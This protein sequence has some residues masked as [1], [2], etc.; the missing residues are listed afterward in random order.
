MFSL[1]LNYFSDVRRRLPIIPSVN[2][3]SGGRG[4]GEIADRFHFL[5]SRPP[6]RFNLNEQDFVG[7]DRHQVEG[8]QTRR[9]PGA[10]VARGLEELD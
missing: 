4:R 2:K 7:A 9:R 10:F 6:I 8:P 5:R 1:L 3:L